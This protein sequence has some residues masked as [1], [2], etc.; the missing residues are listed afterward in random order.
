MLGSSNGGGVFTQ[1]QQQHTNTDGIDRLR[2]LRT[3]ADYYGLQ[4]LVH[5]IDAVTIGRKVVFVDCG[6]GRV[7]GRCL[8]RNHHRRRQ[9]Q[10]QQQQPHEPNLPQEDNNN[11]AAP[12][13][14]AALAE[15]EA[16]RVNNDEEEDVD[17]DDN[18][19]DNDEEEDDDDE[20]EEEDVEEE[21]EEVEDEID[22]DD[23][24]S[25]IRGDDQLPPYKYWSWSQ[26]YGNPD[27][28]KPHPKHTSSMI[29]GQDGSYL[30]L[31]RLAAALPS[32]L[33]RI[34]WDQEEEEGRR[35]TRG[36]RAATR[37]N[38]RRNSHG[39]NH[40]NN[41]DDDDEE[42]DTNIN[43]A[44]SQ[45]GGSVSRRSNELEE[46]YFVTVNIEAPLQAVMDSVDESQTHFPLLRAGLWDYRTEEEVTNEDPVFATFCGVDV[47]SLRAG[48]ILSVSFMNDDI[49]RER[50]PF[51]DNAPPD[52][53]NSLTL[54]KVYGNTMARYERL[55]LS[56]NDI[57][58]S[59][60]VDKTRRVGG[61]GIGIDGQGLGGGLGGGLCSGPTSPTSRGKTPTSN[62]N[63]HDDNFADDD[64]FQNQLDCEAEEFDRSLTRTA[65]WLSPRNDFHPTPFH[66]VLHSHSSIIQFPHPGHYLLLG[67]VA[68]GC[69]RD[70]TF[71]SV[72]S[73][74]PIEGHRAQLSVRSVGGRLLHAVGFVF[75]DKPRLEWA[76][77]SILS[78][79]AMFN[80][81][82]HVPQAGTELSITATGDCRLHPEGTEVGP[83]C[84][85]VSQSLSCLLL[86]DEIME[87][88]NKMQK[89]SCCTPFI[90][91][92]LILLSNPMTQ[93][94]FI[95]IHE[96]QLFVPHYSNRSRSV[97]DWDCT[98]TKQT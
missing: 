53:V 41:H 33:A 49:S 71:D 35:V 21:E 54:V 25:V 93:F 59:L 60:L 79:N 66:P 80:D 57:D 97:H 32:P 98:F 44:E 67:R 34:K 92:Y 62:S 63:N 11:N 9:Q 3:E 6:W 39:N 16:D 75:E 77:L 47:V 27:I 95:L 24:E 69:R 36:G 65:R 56:P 52:L 10:Q 26:Q 28:L 2:R 7:A 45:G 22:D 70:A 31:L 46:D 55:K 15:E 51:P 68:L 81:V 78:E 14:A 50:A 86:D 87:G 20:E 82:V 19:S 1:Q 4:E 17:E 5:E 40:N 91:R 90:P 61:G 30:L 29:V 38:N 12:A 88:M 72:L 37:S 23:D 43:N 83:F 73:G 18:H 48:D 84:S 8:S 96:Y 74:G 85:A 89:C 58:A 94:K 13:A 64:S 76:D 42:D